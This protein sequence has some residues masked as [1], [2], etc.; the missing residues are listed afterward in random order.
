MKSCLVL[1]AVC[2]LTAPAFAGGPVE[3]ITEPVPAAEPVAPAFD[4]TGFYVG[5]SAVSGEFNDGLFDFDTSGIGIQAGYLRD[6]GRFVVGGELAYSSGDYGDLAPD[7]DWD[8]TRVKLIGGLDAGRFL[9]YVFLGLTD[10]NVNQATPFSDTM[11]NYGIG[12]RYA[13][14]S[15]GKFVV[16]LEYLVESQDDFDDTFDA[17]NKEVALRM[18]YRF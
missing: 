3:P 10:Y 7:S 6:L 14:G 13:L 18:D 9:P 5:V 2:G 8:A 12:A 1:A 17:D 16:G 4:W 11:T 15:E